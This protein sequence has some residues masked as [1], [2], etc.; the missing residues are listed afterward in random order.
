MSIVASLDHISLTMP[1]GG[2]PVARAFFDGILGL[3]EI[4]KPDDGNRM[5]GCWFDLGAQQLHLL[6]DDNHVPAIRAHP[7]FTVSDLDATRAA[8][9]AVGLPIN[10]FIPSEGRERFF[11][12]DPFGNRLEFLS[13]CARDTDV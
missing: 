8:I 12:A 7:A 9:Q 1:V 4:P 5:D 13:S 11:S 3:T 6:V 10:A 2:E